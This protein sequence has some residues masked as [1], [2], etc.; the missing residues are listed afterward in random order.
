MS[1]P[2]LPLDSSVVPAGILMTVVPTLAAVAWLSIFHW[3]RHNPEGHWLIPPYRGGFNE[4]ERD[5]HY[6]FLS[7]AR[8]KLLRWM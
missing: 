1:K 8:A 7:R 2:P 3:G 6:P 5:H 4:A